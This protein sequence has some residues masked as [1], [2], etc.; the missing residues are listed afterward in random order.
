MPLDQLLG[1][2]MVFWQKVKLIIKWLSV[3]FSCV[4]IS[5]ETPHIGGALPGSAYS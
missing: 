5:S 1:L 2:S 4:F 3:L